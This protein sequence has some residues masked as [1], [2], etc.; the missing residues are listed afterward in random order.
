M[1]SLVG[2]YSRFSAVAS[3]LQSPF[4]LAVRLYWGWQFMQTGWGHMQGVVK[5][6]AYLTSLNI[7]APALN[8]HLVAGLELFGGLLLIL[9][10]ASRLA[11]LLLAGNMMVAYWTADHD[12]LLGILSD[13]DKFTSAAEITFLVA[14]LIILVFGAGSLSLDAVIAKRFGDRVA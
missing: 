14:A 4:L 10:L 11:G 8:A 7:P 9:G 12:A 3:Y 2:I 13:P 6:T 5:F 1:K